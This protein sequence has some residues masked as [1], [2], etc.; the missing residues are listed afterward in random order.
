MKTKIAVSI[1]LAGLCMNAT[2]E[3]AAS[4]P[5]VYGYQGSNQDANW[6][7]IEGLEFDEQV[8]LYPDMLPD[9]VKD[10]FTTNNEIKFDIRWTF[11]SLSSMYPDEWAAY[12]NKETEKGRQ[13]ALYDLRNN[14]AC[15]PI[16]AQSA[17]TD[18]PPSEA[19]GEVANLEL[20][21]CNQDGSNKNYRMRSYIPTVPGAIYAF[22][23]KYRQVEPIVD[24]STDNNM[25]HY[26][27]YGPYR[28]YHHGGYSYYSNLLN[29]FY[30]LNRHWGS[31]NWHHPWCRNQSDANTTSADGVLTGRI[32]FAGYGRNFYHLHKDGITVTAKGFVWP[33]SAHLGWAF[34]NRSYSGLGVRSHVSNGFALSNEVDYRFA[35]RQGVS[36]ALT[37]DLKDNISYSAEIEFKHFYAYEK[38]A[39]VAEFYKNGIKVSTQTFASDSANGSYTKRFETIDSG[40]DKI[41][42]KAA[43]NGNS[44]RQ[45]DNSDFTVKAI[46][47]ADT[48]EE[49]P[50]LFVN[51]GGEL[52]YLSTEV[53]P[54]EELDQGFKTETLFIAA[55]KFH[56]TLTIQKEGP[57]GSSPVLL[58]SVNVSEFANNPR[59]AQCEEIY[60][61]KGDAQA[62]CLLGDKEPEQLGCDLTQSV[63]VWKQ[64][65]SDTGH[66]DPNT[67][68][69]S[70]ILSES[71]H[72]SLGQSGNIVLR[73]RE[74]GFISTCP[75]FGKT[76][77]LNEVAPTAYNEVGMVKV[78]LQHCTNQELNSGFTL[79]TNDLDNGSKTF[80]SA[81]SFSFSFGEGF[82]NCAVSVIKVEDALGIYGSGAVNPYD[83]DGVDINSLKLQ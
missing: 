32:D 26:H 34:V 76:L 56:T 59:Q 50:S 19:D 24:D 81:Q 43:G 80:K 16:F 4:Q 21:S 54:N 3:E 15:K 13:E 30:G 79:L 73:L 45:A 11:S 65:E 82:E 33:G 5:Y 28:N 25:C 64:G 14:V 31:G 71:L 72:L 51:I 66:A 58:R 48:S 68:I 10:L 35:Y 78:K 29:Y 55:S 49:S 42:L 12:P 2:A 52:N 8:E 38:E 41:V 44:Y 40:F 18:F 67:S 53:E 61:H 47:F 23:V 37:F 9:Y 1:A 74:Q 27:P 46:T 77:S 70:N 75:V 6:G 39:G 20:E 17:A 69:E 83:G 57:D 60:P 36:E 63:M 62:M 22:E 7:V